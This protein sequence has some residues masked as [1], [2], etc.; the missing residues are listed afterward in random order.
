VILSTAVNLVVLGYLF[1]KGPNMGVDF[2]GGTMVQLKFQERTA[3]AS[4]R[5]ALDRAGLSG[6]VIQDFGEPNKGA[7]R[8]GRPFDQGQHALAP[9]DVQRAPRSESMLRLV[10]QD[11]EA[12]RAVETTDSAN[13]RDPQGPNGVSRFRGRSSLRC[14]WRRL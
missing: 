2:A 7:R 3:I 12:K 11:L 8:R 5:Q 14:D 10:G 13:L 1:I 4:I 9:F 6:A